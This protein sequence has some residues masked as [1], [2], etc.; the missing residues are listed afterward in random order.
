MSGKSDEYLLEHP[1]EMTTADMLRF[2]DS[3]M[4]DGEA[5][6]VKQVEAD[7]AIAATG[8]AN[9]AVEPETTAGNKEDVAP[10][11]SRD[12]KHTIPY[13]VLAKARE[14][15]QT[16]AQA[17][18]AAEQRAADLEAQ[19][20]A[21]KAQAV[22]PQ[23][24]A[25]SNAATEAQVQSLASSMTAAELE[26]LQ[27]DFPSL[28]KMI[29]AQQS[30]LSNLQIQL[31]KI[32]QAEA[33]RDAMQATQ[34]ATSVQDTIDANPKLAALQADPKAWER[35]AAL[36]D[37][38]KTQPDVARLP[39]AER[40]AKVVSAYEATYGVVN[41]PA[42][43]TTAT[44]TSTDQLKADAAKLIQSKVPSA[45]NSLSDLR[46]G[47]PVDSD[48]S[49]LENSSGSEIGSRLMSMSQEAREAYLNS[50]G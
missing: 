38:L 36:D 39:L 40:F 6:N 1:E 16:E 20:N 34:A 45:P 18:L 19:I 37:F 14:T 10:V 25:E 27:N 35:A 41:A 30:T 12:G 13:D 24:G 17:R 8:D 31:A 49:S 26:Q 5:P 48:Q 29:E 44:P 21:L 4:G 50:L 33:A 42:V 15:A 32:S 22:M 43:T 7:P 46:G 2:A 11:S 23:S 28:A 9:K 3:E 47:A